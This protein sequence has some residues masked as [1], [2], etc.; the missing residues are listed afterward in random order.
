MAGED[1]VKD[2]SNEIY[3]YYH[4]CK[5]V[6][7]RTVSISQADREGNVREREGKI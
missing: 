1:E 4:T 3:S 6:H 2:D 7:F 5:T